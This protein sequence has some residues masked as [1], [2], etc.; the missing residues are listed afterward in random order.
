M[1]RRLEHASKSVLLEIAK[2]P[3]PARQQ[4]LWQQAQTGQLTV[5]KART[6]KG[7]ASPA[8]PN[9]AKMS[10]DLPE[11]KI[12]DSFS[13]RGSNAGTGV[14]GLGVGALHATQ[15]GLIR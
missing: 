3:D 4:A 6:V 7:N 5:R 14:S 1:F 10:I 13:L 2:E 9:A 12:L 15:P 8:N 11:A